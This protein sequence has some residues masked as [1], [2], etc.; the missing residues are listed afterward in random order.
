[1]IPL[2]PASSFS[3]KRWIAACAGFFLLFLGATTVLILLIVWQSYRFW[4]Q[5]PNDPSLQTTVTVA[6]GESF[7]AIADDLASQHIVA[8]GFWFRLYGILSGRADQI[9]AGNFVLVPG[10][11]YATIVAQM[12]HAE[13]KEVTLTIPE[14]YTL[15]QIGGLVATKFSVTQEEWETL[16]GV[17]SPLN[18]HPFIIAAQKPADVDLEGYLFPDTYRFDPSATGEE[19]VKKMIDTMQQRVASVGDIEPL[20]TAT[21]DVYVSIHAYLTLAS[22]LE[23]EVRQPETMA[24]VANIF[25]K[26]LQIGMALQADS[27]VNYITNGNDPSVSLLDTQIVSRFN[28]Y[29]Y[30]G[31]PPGPISNPG[32]N[33]LVAAAHPTQ[34]AYYYFLTTLEGDVYYA[35]TYDEHLANKRNYLR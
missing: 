4:F 7:S 3:P 33:A 12:I 19:I 29:K 20:G 23:K 35:K 5:T 17:H 32:L 9:Q 15:A 6:A 14:G 30:P 2:S 22:I 34:N 16:T 1:M 8:S 27:T 13:P 28:T 31:L 21:D 25:E 24:N 18:T 26:R 10:T 11:N